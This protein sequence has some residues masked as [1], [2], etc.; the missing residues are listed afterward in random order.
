MINA[1]TKMEDS[2]VNNDVVHPQVRA[3]INSLV[4]AVCRSLSR[5]DFDLS[6]NCV[7]SSADSA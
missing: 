6:N 7:D 1:Q 2:E 3:H 4:S 5:W